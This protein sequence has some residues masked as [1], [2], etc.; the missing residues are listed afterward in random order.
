MK[1]DIAETNAYAK[2]KVVNKTWCQFSVWHECYD[3]V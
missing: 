1:K 2:E 3:G